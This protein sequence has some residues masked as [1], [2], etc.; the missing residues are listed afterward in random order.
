M[1]VLTERTCPDCQGTGAWMKPSDCSTCG[2]KGA[3]PAS[4]WHL[5]VL[6]EISALLVAVRDKQ[7]QI[8]KLQGQIA[9]DL[10][11]LRQRQA[12]LT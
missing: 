8:E 6:G 9:G 11:I 7:D 5:R 2:G 12:E 4:E 10:A 3:I 1:D